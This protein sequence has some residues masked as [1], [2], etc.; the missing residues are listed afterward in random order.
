ML[1]FSHG[2]LQSLE[3]I[4]LNFIL[5]EGWY[6]TQEPMNFNLLITNEIHISQKIQEFLHILFHG[7]ASYFKLKEFFHFLVMIVL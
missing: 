3:L 1:I 6:P 7:H 5:L 4:K 2:F